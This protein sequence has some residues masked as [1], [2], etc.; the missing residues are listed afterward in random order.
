MVAISDYVKHDA[1][2]LAD[3]VRRGE[4]SPR[5]LADAALALIE[6]HNPALNAIT[7]RMDDYAAKAIAS[8]L[9]DGPLRGVPFL[10][11]DLF[12]NVPGVPSNNGSALF[13]G[14]LP[15]YEST[16]V[17]KARE[18]G[19]VLLAKTASPEFGVIPTTEPKAYGPARN[20]WN[21][22]HTPGGSSGGA[23]VAVAA[24]IVPAAHAS[25]GGGSIRIPASCCGIFG[26]KPSRGRIST[27]PV[28]AD[29]WN[30]L[31]TSGVVSRSVRDSALLLDL[32]EGG[33][34]GE[35]AAAPPK[36]RPFAEEV[37]RNPGRLRVAVS[38]RTASHVR[39]D[40]DCLAAL[41]DAAKLM[42]SLGHELVEAEPEIDFD[43]FEEGFWRVIGANTAADLIE[44]SA[45]FGRDVALADVERW[46]VNLA[47]SVDGLSAGAFMLAF[48]N[49]WRLHRPMGDFLARHDVMLTPTLGSPP[50]PLGTL[51]TD[52]ADSDEL[53]RRINAFIPYTPVANAFGLPAMTV[54]L[55]W[56]AA[57]L[58]VGVMF[59]AR[60]G[61]DDMLFRLAAQ[62][63]QA[64]PWKD[65]HP[66]IWG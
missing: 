57:G 24:G 59:Q 18:A 53:R 56:N 50:L 16:L 35:P 3:L 15:P 48:R 8:G 42:E 38:R 29:G 60:L 52:M 66:P 44:L 6:K 14:W 2:G 20:P 37:G 28:E 30:G 40:P 17:R 62:L 1:I 61:A 5:E 63:E 49:L 12:A 23:A 36:A 34:P 19:L 64:R 45:L 13:R 9:P 32:L 54:P 43:A 4:A 58:P 46:T 22:A 55:W 10:L 31:A 39:V 41:D 51:D 65:R 25:D 21:T 27:G 26:L 7:Q 33:D 11:K 47:R